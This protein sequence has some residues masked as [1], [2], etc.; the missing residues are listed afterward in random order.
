MG[1]LIALAVVIFGTALFFANQGL[2]LDDKLQDKLPLV[3]LFPAVYILGLIL[4]KD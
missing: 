1:R 4:L 2:F 3:A